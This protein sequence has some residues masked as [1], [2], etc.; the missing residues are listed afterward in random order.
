MTYA[1]LDDIGKIVGGS[2]DY[3]PLLG[4]VGADFVDPAQNKRTPA[5]LDMTWFPP[6][7][8]HSKQSR[9]I[10]KGGRSSAYADIA[11]PVVNHAAGNVLVE[12]HL[13]QNHGGAQ[14]T[15]R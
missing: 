13:S 12:R 2:K 8:R 4:I 10:A 15:P 3:G 1:S 11:K 5:S 9:R 7:A 14:L 6:L